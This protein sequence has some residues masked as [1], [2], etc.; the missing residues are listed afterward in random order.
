MLMS[1]RNFLKTSAALVPTF[2]SLPLVFRRAIASSV[3]E[4]P[5]RT[6]PHPAR[7]LVIEQLAG[8]NDGLNTL[9]PY[10]DNRYYDLHSYLAV[11]SEEVLD[12]NGEVGLHPALEKMKRLWDDGI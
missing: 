5:T 3:L 1:R 7:T 12:L 2:A 10:T 8:G 4:S 6:M 9:I 11:P